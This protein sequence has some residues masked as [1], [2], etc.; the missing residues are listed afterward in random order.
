[1]SPRGNVLGFTRHLSICSIKSYIGFTFFSSLVSFF[2]CVL[3]NISGC[4][5]IVYMSYNEASSPSLFVQEAKNLLER[6]QSKIQ[7]EKPS[8][9]SN[10]GLI[11]L[12]SSFPS[13][14]PLFFSIS[15]HQVLKKFSRTKEEK[16]N[17]SPHLE[18]CTILIISSH[19]S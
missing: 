2:F 10:S 8:E 6:S 17:P 5:R 16:N 7:A 14:F 18:S 9:S 11:M 15:F 12:Q 4:S 1:M 19:Q 3:W 13:L